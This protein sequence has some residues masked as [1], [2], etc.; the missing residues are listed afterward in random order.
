MNLIGFT[1]DSLE[2]FLISSSM[3]G[4]GL[5]IAVYT[6]NNPMMQDILNRRMKKLELLII[7]RDNLIRKIS[8]D[9]SNQILTKGLGSV[10][11]DIKRTER[12]PY[13]L[14][15]GYQISGVTFFL[16]LLFPI[17]KI[18][19]PIMLSEPNANDL[20]VRFIVGMADMSI[21][22]FVFG[23][24]SF[25]IL[26][27]LLFVEFRSYATEKFEKIKEEIKERKELK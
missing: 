9:R 25:L 8:E 15:W 27:F 11:E 4:L 13:H 1:A 24:F 17:L 6:L 20:I 16:S 2:G 14:D 26:W 18:I 3:V 19:Y 5:V 22:F 12:L 7:K 21:I 10:Q 23:V